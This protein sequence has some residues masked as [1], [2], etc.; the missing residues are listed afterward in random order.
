MAVFYLDT[1]ALVKR[2][3]AEK[4]SGFVRQIT[5]PNA[6]NFTWTASVTCVEIVSALFRRVNTGSIALAGAQAAEQAFRQDFYALLRTIDVAPNI[7][8]QA[9]A[10][11]KIHWLRAYDAIHLASA[12]EYQHRRRALNLRPLLFLSADQPLN[13]AA[14]AE[15]LL[16]DDPNRYP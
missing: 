4:G 6:A 16:V 11:A 10:F 14:L 1:S 7:L 8:A 3:V 15:G 9:M 12:I 13:Q 2:Y 5:D